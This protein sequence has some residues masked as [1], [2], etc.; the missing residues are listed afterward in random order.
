M[1]V[2]RFEDFELDDRRFV[3]TRRGTEVPMQRRTY[4]LVRYL[5]E[6]RDRVVEKAELLR[7]VWAGTSVGETSLKHAIL[8]ARRAL[9]EKIIT[10]VRGRG[11]RFMAAVSADVPVE[12]A[13]VAGRARPP[14]VGRARELER[15]E[16]ALVTA[17]QGQ[18]RVCLVVGEP[19][20]GK[21]RLLEELAVVAASR[22]ARVLWGRCWEM[23]GAP[24]FWPWPPVVRALSDGDRGD[25][26]A[27]LAPLFDERGQVDGRAEAMAPHARF[28]LFDAV[29]QRVVGRDDRPL[30]L[31]FDDLHAAGEPAYRLLQ[32]VAREIR[33]ARVLIVAT[34]REPLD[35]I[36]RE[37]AV[38]TLP[39]LAGDAVGVLAAAL[40]EHPLAPSAL[41][42]LCETTQGNPLFIELL[43]AAGLDAPS[44]PRGIREAVTRRLAMLSD[45]ARELLTHG[46]LL[47]R[48]FEVSDLAKL[49]GESADAT[50]ERLGPAIGAGVLTGGMRPGQLRFAHVLVRDALYESLPIVRRAQLH[51]RAGE[52]YETRGAERQAADHYFRALPGGSREKARS[53]ATAAAEAAERALAYEEAANYYARA[54]DL[55]ELEDLALFELLDRLARVET[56]A[57]RVGAAVATFQRAARLA[58]RLGSAEA[59]ARAALGWA[60]AFR[61]SGV[62]DL[63]LEAVLDEALVAVGP[64]DSPLRVDLLAALA[65]SHMFGPRPERHLALAREAVEMARRPGGQ[66]AL[67]HALFG[68]MVASGGSA[69]ARERLRGATELVALAAG[70]PAL[71]LDALLGE[72]IL[73]IEVGNFAGFEAAMIR[74]AQLAKAGRHPFH[75]WWV[76]MLR[77]TR[78]T[79]Q[80]NLAKAE[81]LVQSAAELGERLQEPTVPIFSAAQRFALRREQGRLAEMVPEVAALVEAAPTLSFLRAALGLALVDGGDREAARRELDLVAAE[82]F[83]ALPRDAKWLDAVFVAA[84]LAISLGDQRRAALLLPLL[85][86]WSED[87]YDADG[88]AFFGPIAQTLGL[89]EELLG[90]A[91]EARRW[92]RRALER[93]E[94]MG[95][96]PSVARARTALRRLGAP[97]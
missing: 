74:H 93:A 40:L 83:A 94:A 64:E 35:E 2:Y 60:V 79:M 70:E 54:V 27:S 15:L 50:L 90:H 3:V 18:G 21:T 73:Q 62:Q 9:G 36:A 63:E 66:A 43:C 31:L 25:D 6:H 7:Q 14:L 47:G 77:A 95:A 16:D 86:P 29:A 44:V 13:A 11:Y 65:I 46:A 92:F 91:G 17:A 88:C 53:L 87:N 56:V 81:E 71:L 33:A 59:L 82:D 10:S 26:V 45:E 22:G 80:G 23:G 89:I 19:G 61:P 76:A 28:Q 37:G 51:A 38:L 57:G 39:G 52:L 32:F 8:L 4:D 78:A 5:L 97:D 67:A 24:S 1:G 34:S 69:S 84:E 96:R 55:M 42:A 49:G 72:A 85:S 75:L 20:M 30:V 48:D 41:S 58:R 68:Q 12:P